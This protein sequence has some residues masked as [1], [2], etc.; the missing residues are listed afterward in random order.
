MGEDAHIYSNMFVAVWTMF[1]VV[2]VFNCRCSE[3]TENKE[4][5][6]WWWKK[7]NF[8]EHIQTFAT[9]KYREAVEFMLC[10]VNIVGCISICLK[11]II[12]FRNS[13]DLEADATGGLLIPLPL[14]SKAPAPDF[15]T[16]ASTCIPL[17]EGFPALGGWILQL[18]CP[19][20]GI[21]LKHRF[22]HDS[23]KN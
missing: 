22:Y 8:N 12:S 21:T 5:R 13:E 4:K 6:W 9:R 19:S 18:P 7:V 23:Q 2:A 1:V 15:Q 14:S 11:G 16:F 10:V 20:S 17:P 3:E